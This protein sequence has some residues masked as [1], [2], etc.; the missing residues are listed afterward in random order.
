MNEWVY[1]ATRKKVG[2]LDTHRLACK[3]RFLCWSA[4]ESNGSHADR[5]D[6]VE[7]GDIVHFFYSHG[8]GKVACFGSFTVVDGAAYPTQFGQRI[9][10]TALF[11]VR[12]AGGDA[13][14]L[15]LLTK[16][17]AEDFA[18]GYARDRAHGCFTGWV[19]ERLP[20]SVRK[21]PDFAQKLFPSAQT[22]LWP[23]VPPAG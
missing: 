18:K 3:W 6:Q 1:K 14:F 5:V 9:A 2:Y 10:G 7:L 15:H 20:G 4:M 17:H 13:A 16:D 8:G 21:P 19:I 11:E 23:Y 22:S 12:E